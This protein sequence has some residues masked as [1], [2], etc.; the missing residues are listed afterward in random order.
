MSVCASCRKNSDLARDVFTVKERMHLIAC[1]SSMARWLA[2]APA[3]DR[4]VSSSIMTKLLLSFPN[5]TW[6]TLIEQVSRSSG[7][8]ISIQGCPHSLSVVQ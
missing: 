8:R 5:E 4:I 3:E 7:I 2:E 6:E 1:V